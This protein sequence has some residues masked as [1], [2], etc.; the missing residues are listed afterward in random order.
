MQRSE[1]YLQGFNAVAVTLSD[2]VN[3]TYTGTSGA[4][5]YVGVG[6][7]ISVDTIGGQTAVV[8]KNMASGTI[9][10]V[11]CV[12]VRTTSTTATNCVAIS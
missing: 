3:V 8:F 6:G 4:T 1:P 10:P 9:L 12:R 7:D 2:T 11:R 5:I